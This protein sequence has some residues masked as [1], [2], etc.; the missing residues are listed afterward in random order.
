[1]KRKEW[2]TVISQDELTSGIYSMW[3]E[4]KD[5]ASEAQAGQFLSVYC[6]DGARLLPRPISLCEI[7]KE[8]GLLRIVYRVAGKG[9]YELSELQAGDRVSV[10]GPLGNGFPLTKA[11]GRTVF[12]I[13]GGI[14]IPPMVETAKQLNAEKKIIAGYRD[15][16]LFLTEELENAGEIYIST[17]DGSKGT[18]GTVLDAVRLEGLKGDIIFACGP[19]PMLRAIKAYAAEHEMEC[20]LSLEERMAC[21]IGACLACVCQ[22]R[23]VDSHAHIHNKRICK[24]GPVFEASEVEF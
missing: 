1:M 12:L 10:L 19:T 4:A 3:L 24:D 17:E 6:N 21:G 15:R 5:M 23:D 22:S 20:Y 2:C 14:G 8:K 11:E 9:T 16:N 7:D 18:K 13:G